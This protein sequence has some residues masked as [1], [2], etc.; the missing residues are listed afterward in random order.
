MRKGGGHFLIGNSCVVLSGNTCTSM[1]GE[2]DCL[3][4]KQS[5]FIF[6]SLSLTRSFGLLDSSASCLESPNN[7][8]WSE[9]I[10]TRA[11]SRFLFLFP[12]FSLHNSF[13]SRSCIVKGA[14]GGNQLAPL[15]SLLYT[16]N[17]SICANSLALYILSFSF[18]SETPIR[19]RRAEKPDRN[20][21]R[22]TSS[23]T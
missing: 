19:I 20:T 16:R 1:L 6:H 12:L 23:K 8:I 14:G 15:L 7:H 22:E 10:K 17:T 13:S 2:I 4:M 5:L 18:L 3:C 11:S 9:T 21:S